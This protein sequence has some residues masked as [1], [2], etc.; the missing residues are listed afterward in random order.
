MTGLNAGGAP[1]EEDVDEVRGRAGQ[2][3]RRVSWHL[4]AEER[5]A[6]GDQTA[7]EEAHHLLLGTSCL[8]FYHP[9]P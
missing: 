7:E 5:S 3:L 8:S 6:V 9:D 1:G 4:S 2:R